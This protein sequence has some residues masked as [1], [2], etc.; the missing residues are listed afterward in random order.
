MRCPEFDGALVFYINQECVGIMATA[1]PD[2]VF[3]FVE[4]HENCEKIAIT[5]VH[6][7]SQV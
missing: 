2:K 6:S 1:V 3:A 7:V 4:M 5:P